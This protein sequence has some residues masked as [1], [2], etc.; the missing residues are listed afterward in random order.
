[1]LEC[2]TRLI[3]TMR[4]NRKGLPSE[5]VKAKIKKEDIFSKE[6]KNGLAFAKWKDKRNVYTLSTCHNLNIIETGKK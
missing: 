2:K 4:K 6:N 5:V 3:G 1:M